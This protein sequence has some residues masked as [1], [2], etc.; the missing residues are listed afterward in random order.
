MCHDE[1]QIHHENDVNMLKK[2]GFID[3]QMVKNKDVRQ[4]IFCFECGATKEQGRHGP[5]PRHLTFNSNELI[6]ASS[7]SR[8][9]RK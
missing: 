2:T 6:V 3:K 9:A 1:V 8:S 7:P 4:S 5:Y